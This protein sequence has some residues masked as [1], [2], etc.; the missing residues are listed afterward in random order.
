MSREQR[1][2]ASGVVVL[3]GAL[4]FAVG[5]WTVSEPYR[6]DPPNDHA[7]T[8]LWV[9]AV[10]LA[11]LTTTVLWLVAGLVTVRRV[12]AGEWPWR[13]VAGLSGLAAVMSLLCAGATWSSEE[14]LATALFAFQAVALVAFAALLWTPVPVTPAHPDAA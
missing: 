12:A 6:W 11:I 3:L 9:F 4:W 2:A 7:G 1:W 14:E 5:A 13:P 8:G 10:G